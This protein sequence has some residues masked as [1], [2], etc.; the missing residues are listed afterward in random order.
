MSGGG[1][2]G[3]SIVDRADAPPLTLS[4]PAPNDDAATNVLVLLH[5]LGDTHDSFTRL[6]RQ[7]NLPETACVSVQ[8]PQALLDLGGFHWGDDIIFD[9]SDAGLDADAGFKGASALLEIILQDVLMQKCGYRARELMLFGFGQGGMAALSV[10]GE[11]LSSAPAHRPTSNSSAVSSD[12]RLTGAGSVDAPGRHRTSDRGSGRSDQHRRG[13]VTGDPSVPVTRM[14]DAHPRLCRDRSIIRDA[15]GGEQAQASLRVRGRQ[16]LPP[17]RRRHAQ[18][19]GRDAAHH[20]VL[21]P[22]IT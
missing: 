4:D 8:A 9:S 10:I 5:G 17:P 14:Q 11:C 19:S 1:T 7:M 12:V 20:A 3:S 6:G 15:L 18:Q 16:A 2:G 21:L 22:P 13:A